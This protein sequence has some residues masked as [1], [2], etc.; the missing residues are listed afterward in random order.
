M[1]AA[2]DHAPTRAHEV[3]EATY[4]YQVSSRHTIG[5]TLYFLSREVYSGLPQKQRRAYRT[6]LGHLV[7]YLLRSTPKGY[8]EIPQSTM[9]TL[10]Q[11]RDAQLVAELYRKLREYGQNVSGF[12]KLHVVSSLALAGDPKLKD[13]ALDVLED[14]IRVD[15]TPDLDSPPVAAAATTIVTG[16]K[17]EMLASS[18]T[19]TAYNIIMRL[20]DIGLRLNMYTCT[21][22][23]Q[24][25]CLNGEM[26]K[27]WKVYD[28]V[29]SQGNVADNILLSTLLH[30]AKRQG[31]FNSFSRVLHKMSE[32]RV[33]P[34]PILCNDIMHAIHW[35]FV[36]ENEEDPHKT[37]GALPTFS[38]VLQV[39]AKLFKLGPLQSLL[40]MHNLAEAIQ[41]TPELPSSLGKNQW[42]DRIQSLLSTLDTIAPPEPLD[43][44]DDT[45]SI[46]LSIYVRSLSNPLQ[47]VT[48]YAHFRNL[49]QSDNE[50][51]LGIINQRRTLAGSEVNLGSLIHDAVIHSLNAFPGMLRAS[52][53]VMRDMETRDDNGVSENGQAKNRHPAPS[54]YTYNHLLHSLVRGLQFSEAEA[55]LD[56]MR[57]QGIMP[58]SVTWNIMIKGYARSQNARKTMQTLQRMEEAGFA[59]DEATARALGRLRNR[60]EL[61]DL[62]EERARKRE[63]AQ[64]GIVEHASEAARAHEPE[65]EPAS[66]VNTDELLQGEE[67]FLAMERELAERTHSERRNQSGASSENPSPKGLAPKNPSLEAEDAFL[68]MERE[69]AEKAH[70]ERLKKSGASSKTLSVTGLA[71]ELVRKKAELAAKEMEISQLEQD[72]VLKGMESKAAHTKPKPR[73]QD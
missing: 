20:S 55:I 39:Y 73:G 64:P 50:A 26:E 12:T 31:D 66:D 17:E 72:L 15:M 22:I 42:Q 46:A 36:K 54:V 7:L 14:L 8:L 30:G 9:F 10:T 47:I 45:L 69:L 24:V 3:L 62:L 28:Y 67:A 70:S 1:A 65:E 29:A 63:K 19:Q 60:G 68:D 51:V 16:A 11:I 32:S 25:F 6:K 57:T 34:D 21:A 35:F 37:Y 5:D 33:T 48:F 23:I 2:L 56:M 40:P 43:P 52:C 41:S 44:G 61:M 27:A 13:M 53:D 58:N 18:L 59:P 38:V 49:I 71:R 4:E